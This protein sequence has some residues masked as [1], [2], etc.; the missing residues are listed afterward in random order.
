MSANVYPFEAGRDL[1]AGSLNAAIAGAATAETNRAVAAEAAETARAEAAEA[2][3]AVDIAALAT[4]IT[5]AE[6]ANAQ[7]AQ[8]FWPTQGSLQLFPFTQAVGTDLTT[9]G[10]VKTG[11]SGGTAKVSSTQSVNLTFGSGETAYTFDAGS[12]V[13][14]ADSYVN[15]QAGT[16]SSFPLCV[17]MIDASN[18]I[19]LRTGG[20]GIELFQRVAGTFTSLFALGAA[21]PNT[22]FGPYRI[23]ATADDKVRLYFGGNLLFSGVIPAALTAATKVGLVI[24]TT[25]YA[26]AF[27]DLRIYTGKPLHGRANGS[28]CWFAEPRAVSAQSKTWFGY[29]RPLSINGGYGNCC[30]GEFNHTTGLTTEFIIKA[31][32]LG[33]NDDHSQPS[34]LIRPDGRLVAFYCNHGDTAI[35]MRVSVN[36]YDATVWGAEADIVTDV[37]PDNVITYPSPV[38]LSAQSNKIYV[39]YRGIAQGL[40][41]I[42]STDLAAATAPA[43]SGAAMGTVT[44]SSPA[45]WIATITSPTD[46]GV[47]HKVW[48]DNVSRIDFACTNATP[49]SLVPGLTLKDVRHFYWDGTTARASDGAA[50]AAF[51]LTTNAMTAIATSAAPDSY[52]DI[53]VWD[54]FRD[55]ASGT[56]HV[57]FVR[58]LSDS[59]HRYYVARWDGQIWSKAEIPNTATQRMCVTTNQ[60]QYTHGICFDPD[61]PGVVYLAIGD[62]TASVLYRL[63]TLDNGATWSRLAIS[64]PDLAGERYVGVNYRPFVPR[65]R[66]GTKCAVMWNRGTYDDTSTQFP[67]IAGGFHADVYSATIT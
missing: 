59:D 33:Y 3:L 10:W 29:S 36:A 50:L 57:A 47:Y 26:N 19:G 21:G 7:Y 66:D 8:P 51:P 5:P 55:A 67:S 23:E 25:T 49:R 4:P 62:M 24:R 16:P 20:S 54:C 30:I 48:S 9:L 65:N 46:K 53:W 45:V 12:R 38:M 28:L 35:H 64:S 27:S 32:A 31:N 58:F 39:F 6:I 13:H 22:T 61:K 41:C 40:T 1:P 63:V 17:R 37:D 14:Y 43:S 2:A 11:N 18:F 44:W 60:P 52:G 15:P 56:V 34:F 42:T